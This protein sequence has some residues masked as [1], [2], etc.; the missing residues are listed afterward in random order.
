VITISPELQIVLSSG[1]WHGV[2]VFA[3]VSALV[4]LLPAFGD[5]LVPTRVKLGLALAF[6]LIVAPAIPV[7]SAPS[8]PLWLTAF[9]V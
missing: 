2:L 1:L 9:T 7:I 4:S 3:R 8:N 6:T 5:R